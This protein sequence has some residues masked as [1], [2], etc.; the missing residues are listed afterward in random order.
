MPARCPSTLLAVCPEGVGNSG[1]AGKE[2]W[3]GGISREGGRHQGTESMCVSHTPIWLGGAAA[4]SHSSTHPAIDTSP[5]HTLSALQQD[6][7]AHTL[8]AIL[9]LMETFICRNY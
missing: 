3:G 6:R 9:L 7:D 2:G 1:R 8:T 4:R 5:S